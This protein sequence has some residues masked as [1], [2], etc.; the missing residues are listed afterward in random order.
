MKSLKD[1]GT[2]SKG[3]QLMLS[4]S[5]KKGRTQLA[6]EKKWRYN[7]CKFLK[8]DESKH[9]QIQK[10][11]ETSEK[12]TLEHIRIKLM[13]TKDKNKSCMYMSMD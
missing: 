3:L 10:A 13:K 4:E 8:F 1:H 6:Q 9:L 11:Q 12:T 2:I 7:G 5:W